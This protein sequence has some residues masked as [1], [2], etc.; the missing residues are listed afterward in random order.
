MEHAASADVPADRADATAQAWERERP[1]TPAGSIGV[2]TRIWWLA[3]LF[4]DDR[5]RTLAAA[6]VDAATLDLL[7]ELR[8]TGAPYQ[9]TTREL[10]IRS[11]VTAGAVSQRVARA[12]RAGL[13]RRQPAPA[14]AVV[15]TLTDAGHDLVER[16]VDRVLSREAEL[17]AD[18]SPAQ[19]Q[20]LADTLRHLLARVTDRLGTPPP[21]GQVG[22][23]P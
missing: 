11:R 19:R 3:K 2:V 22:E 10:A 4:G 13:V 18:L 6:G 8:R 1:G 12:E 15:V 5:R 7:S 20:A 21:P 16:T 23:D 14:R 17:L 9:L